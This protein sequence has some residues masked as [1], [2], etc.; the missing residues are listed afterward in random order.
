MRARNYATKR[1]NENRWPHAAA[2]S[3][4]AGALRPRLIVSSSLLKLSM[5]HQKTSA[6]SP[7]ADRLKAIETANERTGQTP[8]D[9][10]R[11]VEAEMDGDPCTAGVPQRDGNSVRSG[12]GNIS[13]NTGTSADL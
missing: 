7:K 8:D 1:L 3:R 13:I 12:D 9:Q 10:A 2:I 5:K 11:N 4:R 6:E